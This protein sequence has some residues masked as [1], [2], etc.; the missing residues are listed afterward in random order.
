[1]PASARA[2]R[3]VRSFGPRPP[4]RAAM[5]WRLQARTMIVLQLCSCFLHRALQQPTPLFD[6]LVGSGE[7]SGRNFKAEGLRCR[8]I[9]D[10]IE[11]SRLLD[12][13]VS[14]L[15]PAQNLVDKIGSAPE[16]AWPI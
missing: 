8:Q 1:T 14:R 13:Q 3:L 2:C 15:S 11:L 9:N 6:H 4:R 12:W 5:S 10:E 7:Q 16:L